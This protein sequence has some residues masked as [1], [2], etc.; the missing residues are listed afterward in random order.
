MKQV[1]LA[2]VVLVIYH[3]L[4]LPITVLEHLLT[5]Q[6]YQYM[7]SASS[8]VCAPYQYHI[9]QQMCQVITSSYMT[10]D[11]WYD[12]V[13][14]YYKSYTWHER[15][16]ARATTLVEKQGEEGAGKER[17]VVL[18]LSKDENGRNRTENSSTVFYFYI[19][20]RKWKRKRTNRTR[21]RTRTYGISRISKTKQFER[22][23]IEH[24]RY[25]KTQY[26]I[27]TRRP[28]AWLSA[29]MIKFK[30]I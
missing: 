28:S 9:K 6:V 8:I 27:P 17:G 29:Y 19:W 21:K 25:T 16:N 24:G 30:C 2:P 4:M 20:I 5:Y 1:N 7:N 11:G 26:G 13:W 23:Y 15:A 12:T 10:P 18:P 14:Y 3:I 22:N